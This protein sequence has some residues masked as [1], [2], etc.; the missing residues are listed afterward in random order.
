MEVL[1]MYSTGRL[2]CRTERGVEIVEAFGGAKL[3]V[4]RGRAV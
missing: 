1:E 2:W 4:R 3:Q